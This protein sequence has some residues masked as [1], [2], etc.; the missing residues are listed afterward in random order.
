M[1]R[2]AKNKSTKDSAVLPPPSSS[3]KTKKKKK[4]SAVEEQPMDAMSRCVSL[5]QEQK[6]REALLLCKRICSKADAEGNAEM[7]ASLA[8]AQAKIEYSLRRQMAGALVAAARDMLA[9]EYLLDVGE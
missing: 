5:C 8:G 1:A 3:K 9:K 7:Y 2:K 6:W 4:A